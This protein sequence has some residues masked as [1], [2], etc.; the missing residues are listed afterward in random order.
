MGK[1]A[2]G[3][4]AHV[5]KGE[6]GHLCDIQAGVCVC[7]GQLLGKMRGVSSCREGSRFDWRMVETLAAEPGRLMVFFDLMLGDLPF[8]RRKWTF[9]GLPYFVLC[10]ESVLKLFSPVAPVE[11]GHNAG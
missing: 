8:V 4:R 2:C 1:E 7:L 9:H 5:K 11:K 6:G 10:L 3:G